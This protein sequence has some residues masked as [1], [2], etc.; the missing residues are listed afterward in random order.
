MEQLKETIRQFRI[1]KDLCDKEIVPFLEII[2]KKKFDDKSMV[3]MHDNPITHVYFVGAGKVKVFRNDVAG[4]EQIV[5]VKQPG[6]MFPHVGF[7]RKG[8]Y[9]AH[10]QVIED[11]ELYFISIQDFEEVLMA[12]P[13]L[14]IKLFSVLGDQIVDVQQRLEEMALRST[15]ERILLLLLR[16]SETH[17]EEQAN[18]W[19]KLNTKFTNSDLANMIGTTRESVNRMISHLRKEEA[20][21]LVEGSYFIQP[22][23]VQEELSI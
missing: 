14:A 18:G 7:F 23:R 17:R 2:K 20:I 16:L 19:I 11:A 5:C 1:F 3:F 8:D 12:N 4:K 15:N 10:A 9:P 13:H 22:E 21:K 6:D